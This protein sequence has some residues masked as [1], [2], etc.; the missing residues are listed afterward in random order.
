MPFS[1]MLMKEKS[2]AFLTTCHIAQN[3]REEANP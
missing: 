2:K 3:F 1:L